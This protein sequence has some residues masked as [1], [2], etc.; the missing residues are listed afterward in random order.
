[1]KKILVIEDDQD[2]REAMMSTFEFAGY[3]VRGVE[4][5][6]QGLQE[7]I[8]DKP[9]LIFLDVMTHSLHASAFMQRLRDLPDDKND[10]K[11]IVITNLDNETTRK[12]VQQYNVD[13]FLVKVHTSLELL[14]QK[15]EKLIGK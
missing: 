4:T 15:A 3:D 13:E 11:V 12:K 1:M 10:S 7:V 5:S 8:E 6:E 2:M 9:D 14:V